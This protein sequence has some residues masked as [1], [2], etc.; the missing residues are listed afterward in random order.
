MTERLS[1]WLAWSGAALYLITALLHHLGYGPITQL[2][3]QGPEDLRPLVPPLWLSFSASLIVLALIIL[4]VA[5][6][7]NPYRRRVLVLAAC[8]PIVGAALQLAYLGFI[9]PTAML[10]VDGLVVLG[11]AAGG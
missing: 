8:G 4:A 5:R 3:E 7:P 6:A 10:L 9:P 2:A 11:A 1:T